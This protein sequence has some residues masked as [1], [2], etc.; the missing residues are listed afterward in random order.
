MLTAML[1]AC[2][3][4]G[5]LTSDALSLSESQIDS[6]SFYSTHHYTQGYNFQVRT[7][8]LA[9]IQQLPAEAVNDM[10]VDTL[11]IYKN[12]VVVVADIIT[13]SPDSIDSVW[14]KVARDEYTLGWIHESELLSGVSPD[15]P[16][17]E[18]IDFFSDAHLL[19]FLAIVVV[20][21][22]IYVIRHLLRRNAK[23]VHLNDIPSFYP[24][25]LCLL[26]AVSATLYGSIQKFDPEMWRH[27]Y[28]HPTLN[29]YAVPFWLGVF[30]CSVWAIILVSAAV[31]DDVR[32]RLP[33]GELILYLCGLAAT[34]AVVYVVFSVFTL[35]YI[36]YPLLV[37]YIAWALKCYKKQPRSRY[38]CG[39]CGA[40]LQA[41]GRCP[42]CG[43]FNE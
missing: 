25:L 7:D 39:N 15:D 19:I 29:P 4:Q 43:A 42:Q 14:V 31:L 22:A 28:Y 18:F 16:I 12:D 13:I 20:V 5:P 36:G 1:S 32:H 24:T 17:S 27:F 3:N 21:G 38:R 41:K 40:E 26:I 10:P 8:S 2:Y 11:Q 6:I 33:M 30:L 37:A 9:I 34:C 23:I 35:Y